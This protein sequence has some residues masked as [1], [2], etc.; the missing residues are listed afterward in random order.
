[1]K[2]TDKTEDVQKVTD[3]MADTTSTAVMY[4]VTKTV[5]NNPTEMRVTE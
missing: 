2:G 3:I 4:T 5:K 1:M